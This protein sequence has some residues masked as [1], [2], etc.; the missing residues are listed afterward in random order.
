M[1]ASERRELNY[2]KSKNYTRAIGFTFFSDKCF[3]ANDGVHL[4]RQI[5]IMLLE[6]LTDADFVGTELF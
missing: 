3:G 6:E 4:S 2:E 1:S 5:F